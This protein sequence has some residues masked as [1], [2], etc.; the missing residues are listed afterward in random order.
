MDIPEF[1]RGLE[2]TSRE[3]NR[4]SNAIR[5][6]S[7]TSVI[8]GTFTRTPGGTTIVVNDQV[9]GGSGGGSVIP[10]PFQCTDASDE[11][12]LKVEVAWGLIYQQ[13]PLGMMPDNKP[14]LRLTVTETCYIYSRI[15][16]NTDTLLVTGVSFSVET[17]IQSNTAT[18]QYN[19]IAVVTVSEGEDKVIT[20][21]SNICQQPFPSPCSLAPA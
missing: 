4:L 18:T 2:L 19:L 8:G 13:L 12:T 11:T 6:A 20:G 10:C 15:V 14:P 7:V 21:I 9:R 3:L 1:R 16:F 5:S 17:T